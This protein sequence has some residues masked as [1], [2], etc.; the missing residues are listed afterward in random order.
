MILHSAVLTGVYL[1][2][3]KKKNIINRFITSLPPCLLEKG[4]FEV[5]AA[6]AWLSPVDLGNGWREGEKKGGEKGQRLLGGK[7]GR[8]WGR[9]M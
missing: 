6:S 5:L 7:D 3:E 9:G 2:C 4:N 8:G 1:F